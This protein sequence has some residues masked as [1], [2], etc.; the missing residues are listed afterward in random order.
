MDRR[1]KK[2]RE[3]RRRLV[4]YAL[5]LAAIAS[6]ATF[7]VLILLGYRFNQNSGQIRQGGLV[8]FVSEPNNAN[9]TVG[10]ARLTEQTPSKITVNPGQYLVKLEREGYELWK[11]NISVEA[12]KVLWLN[13]AKL[14]P[15]TIVTEGS[16]DI[17]KL[18]DSFTIPGSGYI[19]IL[20]DKKVPIITR[21]DIRSD[22][23]KSEAYDFSG[24]AVAGGKK[25]TYSFEQWRGNAKRA[26]IKHIYDGKTEFIFA[27][28]D[29]IA[30]S[31]IAA[32]IGKAAPVEAIPDPR[33]DEDMVVRYS[34]GTVRLVGGSSG[35]V[36]DILLED[37]TSISTFGSSIV[38]AKTIDKNNVETGY[39]TLDN[40]RVKKTLQ[41]VKTKQPV[42]LKVQKYFDTY[43]ITTAIG[44]DVTIQKAIS[45]PSSSSDETRS[46][47]RVTEF[48]LESLPLRI[49][50]RDIGQQVN[51]TQASTVTNY[52]TETDE[53]TTTKIAKK[54]SKKPI[55][56]AWLDEF[57]YYA[58][59]DGVLRQYEYD[60][61]NQADIAT[62]ASGHSAGYSRNGTY[63]Y[64]IALKGEAFV[65]QRSTLILDN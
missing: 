6:L 11:K 18:A 55:A 32:T 12:G 63:L 30:R 27:D 58:E 61:S 41:L 4:S 36:S 19:S 10:N 24:V 42:Q 15:R 14:V 13:S 47:E 43:F 29:A 54:S 5:M 2:R 28:F 44:T 26:V 50:S 51:I 59:V 7:F 21:Y 33:S 52:D 25:H 62:V 57:H 16:V 35:I 22:T 49:D 56:T 46:L 40:K 3:L 8:Q 17:L 53:L 64:S 1:T 45:L 38:Y 60:G 23:V 48:T 65:L 34:D 31:T 9:I 20:A 37:V 39:I